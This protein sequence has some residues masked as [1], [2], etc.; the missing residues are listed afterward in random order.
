MT[1]YVDPHAIREL[2]LQLCK[3]AHRAVAQ[4]PPLCWSGGTVIFVDV[5]VPFFIAQKLLDRHLI[6]RFWEVIGDPG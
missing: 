2:R 5:V 1:L 4:T 6:P 3:Q